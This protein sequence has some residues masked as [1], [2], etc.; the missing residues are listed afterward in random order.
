MN[1]LVEFRYRE[2]KT[3]C[4]KKKV[5]EFWRKLGNSKNR[6]FHSSP[7]GTLINNVKKTRD[8]HADMKNVQATLSAEQNG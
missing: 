6:E 2:L 1:T 7:R 3:Y 8:L 5:K 4:K